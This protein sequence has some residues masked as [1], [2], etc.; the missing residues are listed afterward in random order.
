M[1]NNGIFFW[2]IAVPFMVFTNAVGIA[3]AIAII[4]EAWRL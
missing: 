4:K 1:T 3:G 2:G